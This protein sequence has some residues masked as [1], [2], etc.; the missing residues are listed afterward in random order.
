MMANVME[1]PR[2]EKVVVNIGVGESG[3]RLGKA[4]TLL[5]KLT[6]RTPVRTVSSHKIPTWNIR[7]GE[8]IGCKV[9]IRDQSDIKELLERTLY[10]KDG[11]LRPGNFDKS[12]NIS[13][14]IQEY[15]DIKGLKYD[16]LIGIF[17]ITVNVTLERPGFRVARRSN[18]TVKVPKKVR[19]SQGEAM[20]FM[21][22]NFGV[23][24]EEEE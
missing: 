24:I 22:E 8:A 6:G 7:K 13:F 5:E 16:P 10:A 19:I 15:I 4:E 18:K 11:M 1:K 3:E 12:G 21:K 2:V 9:T 23:K 20:E 17:G 14:G